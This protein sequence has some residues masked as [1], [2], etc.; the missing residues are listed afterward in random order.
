MIIYSLMALMLGSFCLSVSSSTVISYSKFLLS[1]SCKASLEQGVTYAGHTQDIRSTNAAHT[2]DI[3]SIYTLSKESHTQRIRI[4][5]GV[6]YA[7]HT[8]HIRLEQ[9]VWDCRPQVGSKGRALAGF[10]Q[11]P[12]AKF[13]HFFLHFTVHL[14][15]RSV[16]LEAEWKA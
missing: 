2:Q 8:Q 6:T 9:R 12:I 7:A 10:G 3:R 13:L 4:E 15:Y 1:T 11:G 14:L 16:E 5:Q